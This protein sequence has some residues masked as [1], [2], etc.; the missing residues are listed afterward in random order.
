MEINC[1]KYNMAQLNYLLLFLRLNIP[2]INSGWV[3]SSF[4]QISYLSPN[5]IDIELLYAPNNNKTLQKP[6]KLPMLTSMKGKG[7]SP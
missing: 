6:I 2:N 7:E 5:R 1:A 4:D 3:A